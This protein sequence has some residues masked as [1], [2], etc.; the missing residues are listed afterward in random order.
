MISLSPGTL[1]A[2]RFVIDRI[3]GSGGMGTIYRARDRL[4]E[5]FVA[6]KLLHGQGAESSGSE[7]FAHEAQ[8]LAELRHPGIV[9]YV[10]SGRSETGQRFLAMQWLDGEDL[11][12]RLARGPL[13]IDESLLLVRRVA[14]A[15]AWAHE[16]GIIHRDLKPTNLFLPDGEID[17]VKVLDF[18]IARRMVASLAVT[19]SGIIVGTPGYMAPE[20]ARGVRE[21]LPASDLFSLGCVFYECL[22]GSPPFIAEHL[23]AVLVRILFED[24]VPI[25]QRRP[26]IPSQ[27]GELLGRLLAKDPAQRMGDAKELAS[28]IAGLGAFADVPLLP[29][30]EAEPKAPLVQADDEQ[31]LLSLVLALSPQDVKPGDPAAL[32]ADTRDRADRHG[33]LLLELR[34]MGA[35]ADLLISG[36]LVAAVPQM[37]SAKDQAA[38][39]ARCALKVKAWWPEAHVV[40]VTGRGS[41]SR[42]G[43]TGEALERAWHLL[44]KPELSTSN[45]IRLDELSAGF[46]ESR[47]ELLPVPSLQGAYGLG[48]ELLD[49]DIGRLLL[50][51]PTPCV[52]REFELSRLESIYS[53]CREEQMTRAVLIWAPPGLGKSRLRH[54]FVRRLE[55]RAER[56]TLLLGRGDPM[57]SRTAYGLLGEALRQWFG[58]C[59]GQSLDEQRAL[60]CQRIEAAL[61][62]ADTQRVTVFFG[63]LCGVP[64]PDEQ[65]PQLRAARQDPRIMSDQ[66]EQAWLDGLNLFPSDVPTLLI[67]EDLHWGDAL[68]IKLVDQALR[69]QRD[70]AFMVLALARPELLESYPNLWS[71]AAESLSL[72]PLQ[73]KAGERLVKQILGAQLAAEDM[74]QIIEKSAGN[75]LFLEELIRS[76]A[77]R[78]TYEIPAT[79]AAMIQARIS[80][81]PVTAR[82]ALRAAS[83]FGETFWE[84]GVRRL[85]TATHGPE[86]LG[87]ALEDL[88]REEIIEVKRDRRFTSEPE[89]RFRH[90]L[91]R[92][93]AYELMTAQ[94]S[95]SWH[96][97][98][99]RFL[100]VAGERN[101][102]VLAEHH[103][104]GQQL[105]QAIGQY[106]KAAEQSFEAGDWDAALISIQ[107]GLG[108][109]AQGVP[110]GVLLSIQTI[111]G[112][113]LDRFAVVMGAGPEALTLLPAGSK[114]WCLALEGLF[115]VAAFVQPAMIPALMAQLLSVEPSSEALAVY[116]HAATWLSVVLA[117]AG[118]KD[119]SLL[120]I[121]RLRQLSEKLTPIDYEE[122][123]H[124]HVA[125]AT[126]VHQVIKQPYRNLV[127]MREVV[128]NAQAAGNRWLHVLMSGFLGES[129]LDLGR[130]AESQKLQEENL[131]RSEQLGTQVPRAY[132][133]M[134]IGGLY[135]KSDDP[136]DWSRADDVVV[137]ALASQNMT[138]SGQAHGVLAR[139]ALS[140]GQLDI[141]YAEARVACELLSA[142]PVYESEVVAIWSRALVAQGKVE[143]AIRLCD[144]SVKKNAAMGMEGYTLIELY[145]ALAE[146]HERAGA[147]DTAREVVEQIL[148]ILRKRIEDIPN[149]TERGIY[150][151]GVP[152]NV[153][154]LALAARLGI[155]I[156]ELVRIASPDR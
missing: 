71:G 15:L 62:A 142:F 102:M 118:Q 97:A 21:L 84:N 121:Y 106:Q 5:S 66:V 112:M 149:V 73:R 105:E 17:P 119:G 145:V 19:R 52:G 61:P 54:E 1:F 82:R 94:E 150:L 51:R 93:A 57:K 108:C 74:A 83:V 148:P 14:E 120:L 70:H 50:G 123:A 11:A 3:A 18:G 154:L 155:E 141:A 38:L 137:L 76:A 7:R 58:I 129:L 122:W 152:E 144:E 128:R 90:A 60:L 109:G 29:S 117:M 28:V 125:E 42:G 153:Q 147:A 99:A 67:L 72:R 36:A 53:Q 156:R 79:V 64:F 132:T 47:F 98:A 75:P 130:R 85:V 89:Y 49:P 68:T 26:G 91:V 69:R 16:R 134:L 35:Q 86:T 111:I 8:I 32:E 9:S 115:P 43:L 104:L 63:E 23:A 103:R 124:I 143:E 2:D 92:D 33:T 136:A 12:Q 77:V 78:K 22:A 46:L 101:H 65:S 100:E 133:C 151:S 48:S 39:A 81:L 131:L 24:P 59:T 31:L 13:T 40:V 44:S 107:Q 34:S 140:R 146:A 10:A 25:A 96:A 55:S 27:V 80:R 41:R 135:A 20:Q 30:L 37:T 56:P 110:R 88:I 127:H 6:L 139:T 45:Q 87:D 4:T 116:I 95:V 113:R 114:P 126:Y 138:V